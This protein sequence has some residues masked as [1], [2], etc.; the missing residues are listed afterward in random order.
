MG[1]PKKNVKGQILDPTTGKYRT[2]RPTVMTPEVI[3]KL[4]AAFSYGASDG[5]ACVHAGIS[6]ESLYSYQKSNPEFTKRKE[7]L[8]EKPA[9]AARR[10]IVLSIDKGD[11]ELSKWF[12]T[13]KKKEEFS[14]RNE[15]TGKD[16]ESLNPLIFKDYGNMSLEELESERDER[17]G[18][19]TTDN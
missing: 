7:L 4:E 1:R 18:K 10:N 6:A 2:G 11:V 16:G 14:P 19:K 3:S 15:L 9:L 5:E 12:I 13:R 8:K 17:S